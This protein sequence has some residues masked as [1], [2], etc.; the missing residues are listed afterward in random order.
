MDSTGYTT[1]T[2]QSGLMREMQ[3]IANN[4]ANSSTIGY[5][6]EG[7]IFSEYI[8]DVDGPGGSLSMAEANVRVTDLGQAPLTQTGGT[9]D[10]A[11]EGEGFFLLNTPQGQRLT[12]AGSFTPDAAGNLVSPDGY[13]LLDA[14]GTP[15]FAPP[16]ATSFAVAADG[17]VSAD[18]TPLTQ[19]GIYLPADPNAMTHVA[20]TLFDP[21]GAPQPVEDT[22]ILQGY[23]EQSNVQPVTEI[24][25]MIEVQHAYELGQKF[26]DR[27]DERVRD[28][29]RTLG[30]SS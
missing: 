21:G 11:I 23:V 20:G 17:T 6:R 19:I 2:R 28:I 18:G 15:V 13:Q 12:R 4:I 10:F 8:A 7:L 14:G 16:D 5:R 26:L 27:E 3:S 1:L 25:R 24:T 29:I 9:F 30:S 22:S